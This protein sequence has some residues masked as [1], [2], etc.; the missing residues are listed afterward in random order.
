MHRRVT[1]SCLAASFLWRPLL[2]SR[3]PPTHAMWHQAHVTA[4]GEVWLT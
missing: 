4:K 1:I 2:Q 3:I